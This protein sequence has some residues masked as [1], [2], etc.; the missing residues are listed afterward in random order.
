M[1]FS[2]QSI[3]FYGYKDFKQGFVTAFLSGNFKNYLLDPLR[4]DGTYCQYLDSKAILFC[5]FDIARIFIRWWSDMS[6]LTKHFPSFAYLYHLILDHARP[7]ECP[8]G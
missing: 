3:L 8:K 5:Y 6:H 4:P 2:G 7:A 1:L